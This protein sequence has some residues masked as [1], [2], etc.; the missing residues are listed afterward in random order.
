M[1]NQGLPDELAAEA[2]R[3]AYRQRLDAFLASRDAG[4]MLTSDSLR[5]GIRLETVIRAAADVAEYADEAIAIAKDEYR[6]PL[7]CKEGC[8]YCCAKPGVLISI[9][10]LLRIL[11]HIRSAFRGDAI[12]ELTQR[13]RRYASQLEGRSF[14]DPVDESFP[15]PLLV[16]RYCSVYEVRPLVCRGYNSTSVDACRQAHESAD[17]LVPIFS[18][19]KDVTDGTTVGAAQ[20]LE[21][22][23]FNASLVDLGSALNIALT[24]DDRFSAAIIDGSGPLLAAENPS[25]VG[26]LW[27][28]VRETAR[29]VGITID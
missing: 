22:A 1:A 25:W 11:E 7:D 19:I 23:G 18:V 2:E 14:D 10:E 26:D 20:S 5:T 16:D 13:S 21:A 28:Q 3:M 9:P 27:A 17:K 8:W 6:P 29:Q 4:H 12:S 15:C 24:A